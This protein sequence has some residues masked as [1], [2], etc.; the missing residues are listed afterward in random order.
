LAVFGASRF[1]ICT[2][3]YSDYAQIGCLNRTTFVFVGTARQIARLQPWHMK[4]K[5]TLY[6]ASFS[7]A[8]LSFYREFY[9]EKSDLQ[10]NS[11]ARSG[12]GSE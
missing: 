2:S 7:P 12:G 10:K 4:K 3:G 1:Q 5:E 8:F 6:A 9:T 11:E